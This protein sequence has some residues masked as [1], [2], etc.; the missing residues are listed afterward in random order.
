M[1][2]DETGTAAVVTS[3]LELL[4]ALGA[5]LA[6]RGYRTRITPRD[7]APS[8]HVMNPDASSLAENILAEEGTD[9]WWFWWSWAERIGPAH[10]L[11]AAANRVALVLTAQ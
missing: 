6:G 4:E 3:R 5:E 2:P 8:L 7:H 10:D 1:T 11:T 9:G